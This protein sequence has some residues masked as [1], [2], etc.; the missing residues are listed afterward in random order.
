MTLILR[1]LVL[2]V[3]MSIIDVSGKE[4]RAMILCPYC[5]NTIRDTEVCPVC[6]S[7][8][9]FMP[10]EGPMGTW[11]C[12]VCSSE[13]DIVGYRTTPS[14]LQRVSDLVGRYKVVSI[15]NCK[16]FK[17]GQSTGGWVCPAHGQMF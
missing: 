15:C 14:G 3:K 10:G 6:E 8:M 17:P 2:S 7:L 11:E 5:H 13:K 1:T 9:V 12:R 16:D 4:V